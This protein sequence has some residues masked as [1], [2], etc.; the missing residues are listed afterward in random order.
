MLFLLIGISISAV[1]WWQL[2]MRADE[3]EVTVSETASL[4]KDGRFSTKKK[5]GGL[6]TGTLPCLRRLSEYQDICGSLVT[7]RVMCFVGFPESREQAQSIASGLAPRLKEFHRFGITPIVIF[8]PKTES[9]KDIPLAGIASGEYDPFLRDLFSFLHENGVVGTMIGEWA[10][11]PEIN[12]PIWDKR[13]FFPG[14]FSI[15]V[16]RFFPILRERYPGAKGTILMNAASYDPSDTKW[17]NARYVDFLPYIQD[18]IPRTVESFG[19]Q[20]FPWKSGKRDEDVVSMSPDAF[21]H[22]E[23]AASAAKW[24]GVGR[25]WINSGTFGKMNQGGTLLS[26]TPAERAIVLGGLLRNARQL[27]RE[28]YTVS[29]NLFAEDKIRTSEHIDWSYGDLNDRNN[30]LRNVLFSFTKKNDA[31]GIGLSYFNQ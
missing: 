17:A 1:V 9:G 2:R 19:I 16:N 13:G 20:G 21:L 6:E 23:R 8:E 3:E 24:L 15:M 4:E 30:P 14:D 29:I 27:K 5:L 7:D 11:Y 18:I 12:A 25:I 26:C 28:G 22:V 10:P 31:L